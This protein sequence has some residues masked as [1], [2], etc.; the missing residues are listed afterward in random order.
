M[1]YGY[2]ET[3]EPPTFEANLFHSVFSSFSF[4]SLKRIACVGVQ[5][6]VHSESE[7]YGLAGGK[8]CQWKAF[9]FRTVCLTHTIAPL[10]L[11]PLLTSMPCTLNVHRLKALSFVFIQWLR[12]SVRAYTLCT[13]EGIFFYRIQCTQRGG[14]YI[15]NIDHAIVNGK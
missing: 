15:I 10:L 5:V 3:S 2:P 1:V 8:N 12:P 7:S 9:H 6:S 4:G 14:I 13:K 11:L